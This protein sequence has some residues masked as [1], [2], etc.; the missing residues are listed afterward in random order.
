MSDLLKGRKVFEGFQ[1]KK[2]KQNNLVLED[3]DSGVKVPAGHRPAVEPWTSWPHSPSLGV[4]ISA[5][6]DVTPH[7]GNSMDLRANRPAMADTPRTH[8]R[9]VLIQSLSPVYTHE[10][11]QFRSRHTL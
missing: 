8:L 9:V 2:I 1:I 7:C 10:A 4:L 6:R 11:A 3:T 5:M